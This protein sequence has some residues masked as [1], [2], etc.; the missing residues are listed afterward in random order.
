MFHKEE[1]TLTKVLKTVNAV[2]ADPK[3]H[4]EKIETMYLQF[5]NET[6]IDKRSGMLYNEGRKAVLE[7]KD[8]LSAAESVG[9][10]K[11]DYCLTAAAY[12]HS[13]FMAETDDL[14]HDGPDNEELHDRVNAFSKTKYFAEVSENIALKDCHNHLVWVL[15]WVIDDGLPDRLHRGHLF[16]PEL[17][18]VGIGISPAKSAGQ[19]FVTLI[20]TEKTY[21]GDESKISE[22]LKEKS[23]LTSYKP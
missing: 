15:D 14:T 3:G 12:K 4:A 5:I 17:Q 18:K 8:F 7:A 11:L 19:T 6:G 16:S 2:R 22:E 1:D 13:V 20:F 10:L 21:S 23:G 9:P